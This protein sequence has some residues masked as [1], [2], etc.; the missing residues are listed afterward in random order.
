MDTE[1]HSFYLGQKGRILLPSEIRKKLQL[2]E[3]DRLIA[4]VSDDGAI[5]MT[6]AK[7]LVAKNIGCMNPDGKPSHAVEDL[8]RQRREDAEMEKR[9]W[10]KPKAR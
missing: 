6:P 3:G 7:I 5:T 8:L 10:R 1:Q 9:K 4:T 2:K